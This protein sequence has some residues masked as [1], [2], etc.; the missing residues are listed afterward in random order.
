VHCEFPVAGHLVG[1]STEG[2]KI[3]AV[4]LGE[5]LGQG[6]EPVDE[7]FGAVGIAHENPTLPHLT[8]KTHQRPILA[9][10]A[11]KVAFFRDVLE[12]AL[13]VIGP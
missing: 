2:S 9:V 10:H 5:L 6:S 8:P 3:L 1:L 12:V 13:R 4:K 11:G 7:G